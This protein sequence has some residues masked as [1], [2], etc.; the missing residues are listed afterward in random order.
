MFLFYCCCI[1]SY[2]LRI[3][4]ALQ[5]AVVCVAL[6]LLHRK[7]FQTQHSFRHGVN[8]PQ[9]YVAS[10]TAKLASGDW[11]QHYQAWPAAHQ[12]AAGDA[13]TGPLSKQRD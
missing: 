1:H 5:S 6:A 8:L 10:T 2:I 9:L 13:H 7:K 3:F 11:Q 12:A 4:S